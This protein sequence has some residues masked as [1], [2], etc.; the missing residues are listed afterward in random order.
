MRREQR[1]RFQ[2]YR[3][4]P[5]LHL[6]RFEK[7]GFGSDRLPWFCWIRVPNMSEC[8]DG[9]QPPSN[10]PID[11]P[12]WFWPIFNQVEFTRLYR[13]ALLNTVTRSQDALNVCHDQHY[14][15]NKVT[16]NTR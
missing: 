2:V 1:S 13:A 7:L 8:L 3:T 5:L 12:S 10:D 16:F 14:R 6:I 11:P 15:V 9:S 4:G